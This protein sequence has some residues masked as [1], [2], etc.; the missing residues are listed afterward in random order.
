MQSE[1]GKMVAA[2][3]V[4]GVVVV[5]GMLV[6]APGRPRPAP[7]VLTPPPLAAATTP[8]LAAPAPAPPPAPVAAAE[9]PQQPP[10]AREG[11][12]VGVRR[13]RS[14]HAGMSESAKREMQMSYERATRAFDVGDYEAAIAAYKE[15]YLLGGDAPMLY[16][17]AQAYRLA[18]R[19]EQA[20]MYYRRYLSRASSPPNAA[21]VRAK[22]VALEAQTKTPPGVSTA[23]R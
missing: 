3:C 8:P 1:A 7:R 10:L 14:P 16:N 5:L 22:I 9:R 4:C 13:H 12:G 2:A 15:V 19:P 6:L 20:L 21:D 11:R 23:F 17:I 18:K